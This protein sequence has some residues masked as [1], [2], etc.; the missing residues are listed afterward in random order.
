M[1]VSTVVSA[2]GALGAALLIF[3]ARGMTSGEGFQSALGIYGGFLM[4]FIM[5]PI[6]AWFAWRRGRAWVGPLFMLFPLAMILGLVSTAG[7]F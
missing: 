1:I 5:A 2:L 7:G 4:A 6:A 3:A